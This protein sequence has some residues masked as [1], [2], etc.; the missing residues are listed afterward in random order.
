MYA[1]ILHGIKRG[2]KFDFWTVIREIL[3]LQQIL[4]IRYTS[5]CAC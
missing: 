1:L 2:L 5:E 4:S 3:G